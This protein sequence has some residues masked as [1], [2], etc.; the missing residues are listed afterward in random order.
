MTDSP[1][2]VVV[3]RT[4][5]I[6]EPLLAYVVGPYDTEEEA[7][8]AGNSEQSVAFCLLTIDAKN[9]GYIATNCYWT[10]TPPFDSLMITI[11]TQD[12]ELVIT[13]EQQ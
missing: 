9:E 10:Q 12:E 6:N 8:A 11:S 13:K 2:Y 1:W 7:E 5:M 4:N 3:E